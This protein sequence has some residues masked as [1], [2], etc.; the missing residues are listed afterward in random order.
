MNTV[1]KCY[2][3]TTVFCGASVLGWDLRKTSK[4]SYKEQF[5][6][7]TNDLILTLAWPITGPP[8]IKRIWKEMEFGPY[9][10]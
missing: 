7:I 2:V 4:W 10:D 8:T 1:I 3:Q 6:E 5:K 9:Y